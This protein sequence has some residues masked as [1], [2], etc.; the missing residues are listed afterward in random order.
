M[1]VS[2]IVNAWN[3]AFFAD[4]QAKFTSLM[5]E[6]FVFAGPTPEPL[7]R[8]AYVGMMNTLKA[9]FPDMDNQLEVTGET[10]DTAQ[11]SLQIMGTQT[12]PF[13]LS[14][15]GM[16]IIPPTQKPVRLPKEYFT[17]KTQDGKI[18]HFTVEVPENGGLMG[19]IAQLG[20]DIG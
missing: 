18:T 14:A 13:D 10:A 1:K 8:E 5:S 17:I 2:A 4:D 19:I 6:D 12:E 3:D 16:P 15:M 9:A 11:G 20:V 7:N